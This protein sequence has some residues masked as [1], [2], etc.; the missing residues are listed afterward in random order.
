MKSG[1]GG[2]DGK[3]VALAA[4]L[5]VDRQQRPGEAKPRDGIVRVGQHC[6]P[7]A[8]RGG[9]RVFGAEQAIAV[10]SRFGGKPGA[11]GQTGLKRGLT[12]FGVGLN[13][14]VTETLL[15]GLGAREQQKHETCKNKTQCRTTWRESPH[16]TPAAL[17]PIDPTAEHG[18]CSI[19][20]WLNSGGDA[21]ILLRCKGLRLFSGKYR[22]R[23]AA[24][25]ERAGN[26]AGRETAGAPA[27]MS[28][29]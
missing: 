11:R 16:V 3:I 19:K 2:I 27:A 13:A 20:R 26:R 14:S 18:N 9:T 22:R 23:L 25:R 1:T 21:L 8:E 5:G 17:L 29:A 12:A 10:R 7:I 15:L 4:T 24:C 28:A 6:L